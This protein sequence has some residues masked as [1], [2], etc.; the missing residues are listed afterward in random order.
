MNTLNKNLQ[1][2]F[3][4]I[5]ILQI[6]SL[7]RLKENETLCEKILSRFRLILF[8]ASFLAIFN[9]MVTTPNDDKMIIYCQYID[10]VA[11]VVSA[12]LIMI[13]FLIL[14]HD[15]GNIFKILSDIDDILV[16][17]LKLKINY[18]KKLI[19]NCMICLSNSIL[20]YGI[21]LSSSHFIRNNFSFTGYFF[22]IF[23]IAWFFACMVQTFYISLAFQIFLR[24]RKIEKFLHDEDF[25]HKDVIN[26]ILIKTFSLIEAINETFGIP[27]LIISGEDKF[28]N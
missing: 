18:R 13:E 20:V 5:T 17:Q 12:V 8:I 24:F 2:F 19:I 15:Y 28:K 21:I 25:Q 3:V 26:E 6:F 16:N 27:I 7:I 4:C 11:T 9:R 22:L 14:R 1:T 10:R 23:A